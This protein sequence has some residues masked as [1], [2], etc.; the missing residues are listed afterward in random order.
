MNSEQLLTRAFELDS[1][2]EL[3]HW[4][5]RFVIDDPD[6]VVPRRQLARHVAENNCSSP[7]RVMNEEWGSGL[8]RSWRKWLEL[9]LIVGN[10]LAPLLGA[11]DGEGRR[12]R[13]DECESASYFMP[14]FDFDQTDHV[15]LSTRMNFL[16]IATP[17]R[18]LP[19]NMGSRSFLQ[20]PTSDS[21]KLILVSAPSL[22]V[23]SSTI[24]RQ[25]WPTSLALRLVPEMQALL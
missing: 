12:A 11:D 16:Q 10:E 13:L 21:M 17:S 5:D 19:L 14:Q 7:S 18:R 24:G 23:R 3:A 20:G 25:K 9:P 6:L 15:S 2:D 1:T 8:I 22:F 4:R